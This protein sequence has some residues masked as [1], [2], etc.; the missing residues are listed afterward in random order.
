MKA[1]LHCHSNVS[2]GL[3]PPAEV[4]RRAADRGVEL[5]SL[6]DHDEVAGLAEARAAAEERGVRFLDGSEISISWRDDASFHVVGL[7]IDPAHPPL[8][9]GLQA[10]RDGRD[11]RAHR[12]AA[13]LDRVG[14]HGAYEGAAR[15][16][17]KASIISRAHFARFLVE[18]RISPDVK[19]VFDHY[20]AKGK[21]GYVPH[22][23]ASLEDA[24]RWIG[25]SGG[26]AVLAHP[27]R[28][29]VSR[30]ELRVFLGEFRDRGGQG[31]EVACGA[32]SAEE[33][34]E[35]ARLA[36]HFGLKASVAS[37]FHGPGESFADL[38]M[39]PPLPEDLVPI[40]HEL[41]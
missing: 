16:A 24:L 15:Y 26:V 30:D 21:P 38:G 19:S 36:R 35:C 3:L 33:V 31:I 4:A 12:I 20:L 7:G 2:D 13:E 27:L 11:G 6:T 39:T 23:W 37:D 32:H 1:D 17:E 8:V 22:E 9:A 10:I 40:W 14:I 25:D 28:Y 41:I 29:R 34:H 5:W 18:Q